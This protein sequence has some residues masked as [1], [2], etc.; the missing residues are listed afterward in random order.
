M[1]S[2]MVWRNL[3]TYGELAQVADL[4]VKSSSNAFWRMVNVADGYII[5]MNGQIEAYVGSP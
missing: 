5:A 2:P 1:L 4:D 3:T